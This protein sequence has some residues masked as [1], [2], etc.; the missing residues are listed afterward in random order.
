MTKHVARF[1]GIPP[2]CHAALLQS[3]S[4]VQSAQNASREDRPLARGNRLLGESLY[5]IIR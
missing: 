5:Q 1:H 2:L 3:E 4:Q